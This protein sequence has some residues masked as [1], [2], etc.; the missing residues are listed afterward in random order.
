MRYG[1]G[2]VAGNSAADEFFAAATRSGAHSQPLRPACVI[3]PSN[4][5]TLEGSS[6]G[7]SRFP[8]E[9]AAANAKPVHA[10]I[11]ASSGANQKREARCHR[12]GLDIDLIIAE[13]VKNQ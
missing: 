5:G 1:D 9:M 4:D 11:S 10:N 3:G 8:M 12:G 13:G 7:L 2:P 6:F